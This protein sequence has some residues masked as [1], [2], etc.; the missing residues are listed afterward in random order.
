MATAL[1]TVLRHIHQMAGP[2]GT[3]E[4]TDAQLLERFTHR[5]EEA[6][7]AALVRRHGPM[8]LGVCRRMLG[9][10]HDAEDAFQATFLILVRKASRIRNP[11]AVGCWLYEVAYRTASRARARAALR[12]LHERRA[13][14]MSPADFLTPLIWQE[15]GPVLDDEVRRLS[16]RFRAPFVLCYLEGKTYEQAARQLHLS[17]RSLSR[18]LARAREVLRARLARRGLALSAGCLATLLAERAAPA[19]VPPAL[20]TDTV[21]A[22]LLGAAGETFPA[23]G[24]PPG[25]AALAEGSLRTTALT[26]WTVALLLAL[27]VG[28]FGAAV[29]LW[30]QPSP[31]DKAPPQPAKPPRPAASRKPSAPQTEKET[32]TVRGRV[33]DAG[34]KPVAGAHV[35][36]IGRDKVPSRDYRNDA[37]PTVLGKART[38]RRGRF[39]V[40]VPRLSPDRYWSVDI[41]AGSP[42]HGMAQAEL[43][44]D[45]REPVVELKLGKEQVVRGRLFDLQ[46]QPAKGVK[47]HVYWL[48]QRLPNQLFHGILF[49]NPPEGLAPWPPAATSDGQGRFVVRGLG[50]DWS[51]KLQ[52]R[53]SRFAVQELESLAE[54]RKGGKEITWALAPARI[55]EGTVTYADTGKPVPH[56][57]LYVETYE[58]LFQG[59]IYHLNSR[60]DAHGRFRIVS[61]LGKR[62]SVRAYPPAGEPYLI[63]SANVTWAKADV[64]KKEVKLVLPRGIRVRGTITEKASGRPVAGA[65]VEFIR[66]ADKNPFLNAPGESQVAISSAKGRFELAVV[67]GPGRL[68]VK[69]PTPDYIHVE[70]TSQKLHGSDSVGDWLHYPDAVVN[71]DLKPKA[72]PQD[73][74]VTLNRG[75]TV[76]GK[77]VGPDGKPVA[78][79]V[80]YCKTFLPSGYNLN[81]VNSRP[82]KDGRF[83]LPGCDPGQ[84]V[85]AFFLDARNRLGAVALLSGKQAGKPVTVKLQRCGTLKVRFVDDRG[86]PFTDVY[87]GVG[88]VLTQ[89]VPFHVAFNLDKGPFAGVAYPDRKNYRP[90]A[91]GRVTFPTIVPGA[92]CWLS[93][94]APDRTFYDFH[95]EFKVASGKT[96]DLGDII[97]KK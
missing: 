17:P 35:A 74:T 94:N 48:Y 53:D 19:A 23:A 87:P 68:V 15:V 91:E 61:T 38:D 65:A 3:P 30:A 88:I 26:R 81:G 79:A 54:D 47:V 49:R 25:V 21:R 82:V 8:V 69:G 96:V 77:V 9:N 59:R 40:A 97:V 71:L 89:G 18:R 84:T 62:G 5:R 13:L 6:A 29:G 90:D 22:A 12:R 72:G 56:A 50:P 75:V 2:P 28:L 92:T 67:P 58:N 42:G 70:T 86:K 85:Q 24:I 55:I 66:F 63:R 33:L 20:A 43:G 37:G 27:A 10:P 36:V 45:A 73:V 34:G 80:L 93:G 46:G 1:S 83:D 95:K 51:M 76:Q 78:R 44:L 57:R 31:A 39:R 32:T 41:L 60:T 11:E 7:F 52:A 16:D 14:P 64:L 4:P